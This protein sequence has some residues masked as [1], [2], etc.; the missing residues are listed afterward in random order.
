MLC[1]PAL[2]FPGVMEC[3]ACTRCHA[4][5]RYDRSYPPSAFLEGFDDAPTWI[6]GL[7]PAVD[8]SKD[9]WGDSL[10][11]LRTRLREKREKRYFSR[12]KSVSPWLHRQLGE[13][14]GVAHTDLVRCGSA[15]FRFASKRA[16]NLSIKN[17][18]PYLIEQVAAL[19]PK[20]LIANGAPVA[21]ALFACAERVQ[22][23]LSGTT[24]RGE[25]GGHELTVVMSG[26]V[27]RLDRYACMRLGAEIH[28]HATALG[29][30]QESS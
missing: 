26:F 29:L 17:C 11:M 24:F 16:E 2:G 25:I 3:F 18:T 6:V 15:R 12:F 4:P 9:P 28:S 13:P 21:D 27:Q 10:E 19:R 8:E 20:L 14:G 30:L 5:L 23:E 22:M 7:N 1:S